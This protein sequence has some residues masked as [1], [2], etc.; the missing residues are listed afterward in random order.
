MC[1]ANPHVIIQKHANAFIKCVAQIKKH[2]FDH[3]SNLLV[4]RGYLPSF[5]LKEREKD[6]FL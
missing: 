1:E 3:S 2:R 6:F 4:P 5:I